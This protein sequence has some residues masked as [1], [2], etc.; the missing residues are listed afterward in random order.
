MWVQRHIEYYDL[1]TTV[2]SLINNYQS[3]LKVFLLSGKLQHYL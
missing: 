3:S 2:V 1:I